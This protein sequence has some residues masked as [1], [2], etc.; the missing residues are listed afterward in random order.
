MTDL[1]LFPKT[2]KKLVHVIALANLQLRKPILSMIALRDLALHVPSHLLQTITDPKH[3][4]TQLEDSRVDMWCVRVVH[5][6]R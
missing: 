5:G 4:H 6:I 3:R 2:L 1:H